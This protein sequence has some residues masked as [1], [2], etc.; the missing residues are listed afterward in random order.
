MT[1]HL[2]IEMIMGYV[3]PPSL[4]PLP[5][6]SPPLP[7]PSLHPP[8]PPVQYSNPLFDG[9]LSGDEGYSVSLFTHLP[10]QPLG[11][12]ACLCNVCM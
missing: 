11:R 6:P 2:V 3:I 9:G 7:L 5:P 1:Q 12:F 4:L 8:I 10:C